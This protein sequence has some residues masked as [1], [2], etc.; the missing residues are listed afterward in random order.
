MLTKRKQI[1]FMCVLVR[2]W[3]RWMNN[4]MTLFI[5]EWSAYR[6]SH[7]QRPYGN[8]P[9]KHIVRRRHNFHTVRQFRNRAGR[10]HTR[11]M[12]EMKKVFFFQ[13]SFT[14]DESKSERDVASRW[15]LRK[16]NSLFTSCSDKDQ[17]KISLS[18]MV[19]VNGPLSRLRFDKVQ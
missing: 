6:R 17:R 19:G 11:L 18:C 5:S 4:R 3:R 15:I 13:G 1:I 16:S 8:P 14:L 10:V 2:R 12:S 7:Y 9:Y